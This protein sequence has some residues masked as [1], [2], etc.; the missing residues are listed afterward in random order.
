M[1]EQASAVARAVSSMEGTGGLA[2]ASGIGGA[3]PCA[4]AERAAKTQAGIRI[5][6]ISWIDGSSDMTHSPPSAES[7]ALHEQVRDHHA[8]GRAR[9]GNTTCAP[10]P[11]QEA[12]ATASRGTLSHSSSSCLQPVIAD[13]MLLRARAA[14]DSGTT[15]PACVCEHCMTRLQIALYRT[16][17]FGHVR[18][19][20]RA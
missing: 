10:G 7:R 8:A 4:A 3:A 11:E 1:I 12:D 14:A 9:R 13:G 2:S 5:F 20:P 6:L 17:P 19:T 18:I 15:L 16:I